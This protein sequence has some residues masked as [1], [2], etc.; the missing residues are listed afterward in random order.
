MELNTDLI[1][2]EERYENLTYKLHENSIQGFV[3]ELE[4]LKQTIYKILSTPKYQHEIYSF[5]YGVDFSDLIGEERE[6]IRA[7]AS[8]KIKEALEIDDRILDVDNFIF[9]FKGNICELSFDIET[10]YGNI[11]F[12]KEVEI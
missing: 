3:N 1:I 10:I 4:A 11:K 6:Y 5:N 8:R 2:Q 7:E 9:I 12:K